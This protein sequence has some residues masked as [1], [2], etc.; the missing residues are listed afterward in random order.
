MNLK[1]LV[2]AIYDTKAE[3]Y[4]LPFFQPTVSA[5]IRMFTDAVNDPKTNFFNHSQDY[6]LFLIGEYDV[7]TGVITQKTI[8][9]YGVGSEFK[10]ND[11]LSKV[12]PFNPAAK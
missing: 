3:S 7:Q 5:A 4:N 8:T 6:V 11:Q 10:N 2:F 1:Q 9:S 12:V